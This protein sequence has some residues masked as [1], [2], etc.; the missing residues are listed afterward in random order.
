[1][2]FKVISK[3]QKQL[4]AIINYKLPA[5][6]AQYKIAQMVSA[7]G[8]HSMDVFVGSKPTADLKIF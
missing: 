4:L 8:W 1:M 5:A 2:K 7:S 6:F 3:K